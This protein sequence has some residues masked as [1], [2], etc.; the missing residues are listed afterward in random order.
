MAV[1]TKI[2]PRAALRCRSF[3]VSRAGGMKTLAVET[4]ILR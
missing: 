2:L 1:K 3:C 4:M